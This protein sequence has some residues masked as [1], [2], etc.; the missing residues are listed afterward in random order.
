MER[1]DTRIQ[2]ER[3]MLK[4]LASMVFCGMLMALAIPAFSQTAQAT[5][6]Q[7]IPVSFFLKDVRI[8]LHQVPPFGWGERLEVTLSGT[9]S[10]NVRRVVFDPQKGQDRI[11]KDRSQTIQ[12]AAVVKILTLFYASHYEGINDESKAVPHLHVA[13]DGSVSVS[14]VMPSEQVALC[15]TLAIGPYRREICDSSHSSVRLLVLA[16]AVLEAVGESPI[17]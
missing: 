8:V 15:I 10:A 17:Q 11:I 5:E 9:G 13:A 2:G 7:T 1:C 4:N 3:N 6:A 12:Q 14:S 16:K